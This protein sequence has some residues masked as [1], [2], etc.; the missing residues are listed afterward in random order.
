MLLDELAGEPA[1]YLHVRPEIVP[2][3]AANYRVTGLKKM[4]RML[5]DRSCFHPVVGPD[6]VRLRSADLNCIERLYSDGQSTGEAPDFF[7]PPM[8]KDGV[9]FGV[10]EGDELV[11]VA[12][13]HLAVPQE[14]VAAVGN[15]YTRRD[16]RGRGLAARVSS[17][18]VEE[19]MRMDLRIVLNVNQ[20][21]GAAIR[22]YERLGFA[23]YC[24]FIEGPAQRA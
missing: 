14:E 20:Q 10:R 18:V 23:R 22:V 15:V 13:T 1:F 11:S 6:V 12:G 7:F 8:L 5:L 3:L 4:W 9:F 24:E 19:L 16:R 2:V 21:N 17:A